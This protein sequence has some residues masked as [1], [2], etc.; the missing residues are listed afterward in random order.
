MSEFG[1]PR[2][3][4]TQDANEGVINPPAH[5]TTARQVAVNPNRRQTSSLDDIKSSV[6]SRIAGALVKR[7]QDSRSNYH[8]KQA[9]DA[10][11][12]QGQSKAINDVDAD[13]KRTGWTAA[14]FGQNVAYRT[15]Q[16]R[17]ATNSVRE[18]YV[19][20][21]A[22]MDEFAG[23]TPDE[24]SARLQQG[25]DKV[26]EPHAGDKETR[27]LI[28]KNWLDVSSK[29]SENQYKA[30]YAY[31]QQ[32]QRETYEKQTQLKFDTWTVDKTH[33]SSVSGAEEQLGSVFDFFDGSDRPDGMADQAWRESVNNQLEV[34]LRN[35]NIGAYHMAEVSGWTKK[36]SPQEKL[37][38][39]QALSVYDTDYSQQVQRT[40]AEANLSAL[41][42]R[43]LEEATAIYSG[44]RSNLGAATL[45]SSGTAASREAITGSDFNK[46]IAHSESRGKYD[47]ENRLG[48]VGKYQFGGAALQD[49]GYKDANGKWT[50]KDGV[51][52]KEDWKNNP[53]AQEAAMSK[54]T[55]RNRRHLTTNDAF[56]Q[57]GK[58]L[59]GV[60]ITKQGLLAA[61][62]LVGAQG[63]VDMLKTGVI[64]KDANGTTALKYMSM[65]Q[66]SETDVNQEVHEEITL[67]KFASG[68]ERS[69]LT[70]AQHKLKAK[71]AMDALARLAN[72]T[73]M[74]AGKAGLEAQAK[75]ERTDA[76]VAAHKDMNAVSRSSVFTELKPTNKEE[77]QTLDVSIVDEVQNA[78]GLD[79]PLSMSETSKAILSD[80]NVAK[81]IARYTRGKQVDSP[82]IK[83]AIETMIGS[84]QTMVN[85]DGRMNSDGM[86]ALESIAQFE[87]N[88]AEF[89]DML[90]GKYDHYEIIKR[91]MYVGQTSDMIANEIDA[92]E[93][94]KGNKAIYS[95]QWELAE[96]ESK[97]D[98]IQSLVNGWTGQTP[99]GASLA[100]YMEE[101][102]RALIVHQ[103][104]RK[105]AEDYLYKSVQNAGIMYDGKS[106]LG[107]K[108]LNKVTE[109]SLETLLNFAQSS[110]GANSGSLMT[111][112]L[113]SMGVNVRD[114]NGVPLTSLNQLKGVEFYT[115]DGVAGMYVT[116]IGAQSDAFVS[117]T[118][119]KSWSK[120]MK[121]SGHFERMREEANEKA[122]KEWEETELK[123]LQQG[124]PN[125][126]GFGI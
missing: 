44:L 19:E 65:F 38:M 85:E 77:A 48:Y 35:G 53:D 103:G 45:R 113:A 99:N 117:D 82:M 126:S 51:S 122:L 5:K 40:Y 7:S 119:L 125:V 116:A 109:H 81:K 50:G 30:H 101:F 63:V 102:D 56:K 93:K 58:T 4:A 110:V 75:Q 31:N 120:S 74:K 114:E 27:D 105:N 115:I 1:Q 121:Q 18:Q 107:G 112:K 69:K 55:S 33:T 57:V 68:T 67:D 13:S 41:E 6:G 62:H 123:G 70:V 20:Q 42:A 72:S 79:E 32:Q 34:A 96:N 111:G 95:A 47:A 26:L 124:L 54:L 98:R 104:D 59:Q 43:N 71:K 22:R 16:Q 3:S 92:Y 100:H 49:T 106:I 9:N 80:V 37:K 15:A 89:K 78:L 108:R 66:D 11:I 94:N 90:G 17:A 97:R 86:K 83:R 39:D 25:L 10:A 29:L 87:Q 52:S 118:D 36:L 73:A 2:R 8:E 46:R 84:F 14:I 91:G 28:T 23:E 60:V 76:L 88:E 21:T 61:S 64:P 24:Y 12:R